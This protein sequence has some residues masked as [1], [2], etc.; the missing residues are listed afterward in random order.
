MYSKESFDNCLF[1]PLEKNLLKTYPRLGQLGTK[2]EN[3]LRYVGLLYDPRSPLVRDFR[4]LKMRKQEAAMLA[5]YN[6][7]KGEADKIFDF[8]DKEA[9]NAVDVYLKSFISSRLWYMI[10][11][12]EQTIY[13]YAQRMLK[14]VEEKDGVGE[15]D[16]MQSISIKSKLSADMATM[17][18]LLDADYNKFFGNDEDL[19]KATRRGFTPEEMASKV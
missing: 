4:D 2:D 14:P 9:L 6:L 7:R 10:N 12:R 19:A 11:A 8:S 5:G 18:E 13:E 15:K 3:L 1:N 17:N 16:L